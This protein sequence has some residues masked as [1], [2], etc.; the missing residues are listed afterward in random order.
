[1]QFGSDTRRVIPQAV[2]G[3]IDD[4]G[5]VVVSGDT[6]FGASPLGSAARSQALYGIANANFNLTP[7]IPENPIVDGSNPLPF[8][9]AD[10]LSEGRITAKMFYNETDQTFAVELDPTAGSASDAFTLTTRSYLLNDSGISLRQKAYATL[11][12]VNAYSSTNQ[13][14]LT[15]SAT[16]YDAAGVSLS[17]FTIGTAADNVAFTGINGFTTTGTAIVSA[18]AQYVDLAFTLT[19]ALAVTSTVK[20]QIENILLQTSTG[21]GGGT[22]SFILTETFTSSATWTRPTGVTNILSVVAVGAGAGGGGGGLQVVSTGATNAK[23]DGGQGG[24]MASV[25]YATNIPIGTVASVAIGVGVGGAGGTARTYVK[26]TGSGNVAFDQGTFGGGGGNTTFGTYVTAR[27]GSA[28]AAGN[29]R[30]NA[31]GGT[32]TSAVFGAVFQN[33]TTLATMSDIGGRPGTP[34]PFVATGITILPSVVFS[35]NKGSTGGTAVSSF[36]SG[37]GTAGTPVVTAGS[38]Y[39]LGSGSSGGGAIAGGGGYPGAGSAAFYNGGTAGTGGGGSGGGGASR[40]VSNGGTFT[41]TGGNGGAGAANSGAG[42]GGGGGVSFNC[43]GTTSF[44]T[45]VG[46][47]TSGTGGA[48]GDGYLVITYVG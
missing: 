14:N 19:C 26:S 11:T 1:M 4:S 21:G 13:W 8:W 25:A 38:G 20:V 45:C 17:S 43:N 41:M 40:G 48:G 15:L 16:Y 23:A 32:A 47:A 39:F 22:S 36:P 44:N 12:K 37:N 35:P 6:S 10:D 31:D 29:A 28:A 42:G 3:I 7:N 2:N 5:N 9:S 24:G 30:N 34:S 33:G 46:T 27:G 18:S